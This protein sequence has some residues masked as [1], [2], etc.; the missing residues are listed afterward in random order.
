MPLVVERV[1]PVAIGEE[2]RNAF[3]V[4]AYP[5][6]PSP[7][8]RPGMKGV[9]Q[10]RHRAAFAPLDLD[11]R[12][13][14]LGATARLVVVALR[15]RRWSRASSAPRGIASRRCGRALR[16]HARLHRHRYR[17][18]IWYVVQ[19]PTSGRCHR[20]TESAHALL[21]L[22]NGARTT[23]RDLG[24]R[25][26]APRRRRADA[27]RDDPPARRAP[28][29]RPAALRHPAGH[30]RAAATPRAA[31]AQRT[32]GSDTPARSP[33]RFSLVDPDRFLDRALPLVRPLFTRAG[34]RSGASWWAPR[35]S[36]P[37]VHWHELRAGAAR[38]VLEPRNL[39]WMLLVYPFVKA[40]HELGHAFAAKVFGGEVHDMGIMLLVLF[41]VPYVDASSASV[42]ADK[43]KRMIVGAAGIGVELFLASVALFVWLAVEPGSVRSLAL[44][45]MSV[46]GLSTLLFNGNPLLR[47]DGYYVLADA[48]EIPNLDSRSKQYLGYPGAAPSASV[49]RTP[50][51][52]R[53]I[54]ARLAGCVVYARGRVRVPDRR[55]GGHRAVPRRALLRARESCSRRSAWSSRCWCRSGAPRLRT[56]EPTT[57][58]APRARAGRQR[59]AWRPA[60]W[61]CW[62]CSRCPPGPARRASCGRPRAPRC[63]PARTASS[64]ASRPS[65]MPRW[66][67]A[68]RW[69]RCATRCSRR[70]C[71]RSRRAGARRWPVST[72]SWRPIRR[73]RRSCARSSAPPR[74]SSRARASAS[75]SETV[76]SA[77]AGNFVLPAGWNLVGRYVRRGELLG[78][79]VGPVVST[80]RVGAAAVRHRAGAR[81]DA[82]RRGAAQPPA[83]AGAAR[84]ASCASCRARRT[85]LPSPALGSARRR[86]LR[87]RP[88][89]RGADADAGSR[90]R[91]GPR[92]ARRGRRPRDRR[93]RVR[94]LRAS[95]R[96]A[97][98]A[99]L[100][101]PAAACC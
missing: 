21:L 38:D 65:P 43:R 89:R 84:D 101:R 100:A 70:R 31:R 13:G 12:P 46:G 77:A 78:Y 73:A 83:R 86:S 42:L 53:A 57:G 34:A 26:R 10:D 40:L 23:Q 6:T 54:G 25:V 97:R 15:R 75:A 7:S 41:P 22:M 82:G 35:W 33:Q 79:V 91:A 48:L 96:A 36:P 19:D 55:A 37:R 20:I 58:R 64:C 76:R 24:R 52:P 74:S 69:C 71:A 99:G 81:R 4:E 80:V 45:V 47:F 72:R 28:R 62:R 18:R 27:G 39:L 87:H 93:P 16:D 98:R 49:W 92:A 30:A 1:T 61:C 56:A 63:A 94:A 90:L 67:S 44:A 95:R 17:G 51:I 60:G 66:R 68:I 2:G 32:G 3:R 9:A 85:A 5:E 11:P 88:D 50:R 8:L 14:R 59:S 29:R